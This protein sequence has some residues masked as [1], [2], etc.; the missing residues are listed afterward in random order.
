M[1]DQICVVHDSMKTLRFIRLT[2][3][4]RKCLKVNLS[5]LIGLLSTHSQLQKLT[6]IAYAMHSLLTIHHLAFEMSV[7]E[8]VNLLMCNYMCIV[9]CAFAKR[10][11]VEF[12][13]VD[14]DDDFNRGDQWSLITVEPNRVEIYLFH[15]KPF[16][17]NNCKY[18]I[19]T[20]CAHNI[21]AII[22]FT[23]LKTDTSSLYFP[24]MTTD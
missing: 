20:F 14:D 11:L 18:F 19:P 23:P 12:V 2:S 7:F 6:S 13:S 15:L 1:Y 17:T 5:H 9:Q 16:D 22:N 21:V 24:D 8:Y 3:E 4:N 10:W